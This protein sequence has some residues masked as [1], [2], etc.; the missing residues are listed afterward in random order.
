[1][2]RVENCVADICFWL[3]VNVLKLNHD[4]KEIMFIYSKYHIRPLLSNFS[5]GNVRLTTTA[6]ARTLEVVLDDST[7]FDVHVSDIC[8]SS[9]YQIRNLSKKKKI[10]QKGV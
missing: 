2:L 6:N 8:R 7:L 10:S 4:K 1:M 9:F 5:M 3:D